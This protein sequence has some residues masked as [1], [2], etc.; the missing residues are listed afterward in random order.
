MKKYEVAVTVFEI[1][2]LHRKWE[3]FSRTVEEHK[4]NEIELSATIARKGSES[5]KN[6]EINQSH[7]D[8]SISDFQNVLL[9]TSEELEKLEG[10]ER[11]IKGTKEKCLA[12]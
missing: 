2:E 10:Q 8:E 12:K 6:F 4:K 9:H 3:S 5:L 11:S 1:E 7:L